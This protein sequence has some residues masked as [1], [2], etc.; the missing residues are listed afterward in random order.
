MLPDQV[1]PEFVYDTGESKR[2]LIKEMNANLDVVDEI[3]LRLG[4]E[5]GWSA[6]EEKPGR[7]IQKTISA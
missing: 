5:P 7:V 6:G 1:R 3:R 2:W 4:G